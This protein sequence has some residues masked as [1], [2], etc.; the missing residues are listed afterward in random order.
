MVLIIVFVF[1]RIYDDQKTPK[2][3][4]GLKKT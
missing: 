3:S 2:F 4:G 1:V